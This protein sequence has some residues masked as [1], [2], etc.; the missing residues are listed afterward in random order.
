[1]FF[2]ICHG[3]NA[4]PEPGHNLRSC[5]RESPLTWS[6]PSTDEDGRKLSGH[7]LDEP[8]FSHHRASNKASIRRNVQSRFIKV[9]FHVIED[10]GDVKGH[11]VERIDVCCFKSLSNNRKKSQ[12]L[13]LGLMFLQLVPMLK[14]AYCTRLLL[15]RF[16][17]FQNI[18]Q[19]LPT[20]SDMDCFGQTRFN[21]G[22]VKLRRFVRVFEPVNE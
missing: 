3:I 22:S 8:T 12:S 21:D 14:S 10:F 16:C 5:R 9:L 2:I 11:E 1:M 19:V 17:R 6:F 4:L 7:F 13:A 15:R 18:A 20:E